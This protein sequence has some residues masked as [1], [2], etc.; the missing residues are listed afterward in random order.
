MSWRDGSSFFLPSL[1]DPYQHTHSGD[2]EDCIKDV[3]NAIRYAKKAPA[4]KPNVRD[5]D[6]AY[7]V[8]PIHLSS[9][10]EE[11]SF[12]HAL[13]ADILKLAGPGT[14]QLMI[15]PVPPEANRK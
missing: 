6:G 3:I 15:L 5:H 8:D 13:H 1:H 7:A 12:G 2:G 11:R 14:G 4:A 9:F 10:G